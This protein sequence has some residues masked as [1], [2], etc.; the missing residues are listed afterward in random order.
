MFRGNAL[1]QLSEAFSPLR[2][3][4]ARMATACA[5]VVVVATALAPLG[6]RA[7]NHEVTTER[8]WLPAGRPTTGNPVSLH[9][10]GPSRTIYA[11][12]S[13]GGWMRAYDADSLEPKTPA[14]TGLGMPQSAYLVDPSGDLIVAASAGL[15]GAQLHRI[16]IRNGVLVKLGVFDI[17]THIGNE[18]AVVSLYRIPGSN[19]VWGLSTGPNSNGVK[20]FEVDASSPTVSAWKANWVRDISTECAAPMRNNQHVNAALGYLEFASS[21]YFACGSTSTPAGRQLPQLPGVA[22]LVLSGDPLRGPTVAQT[23]ERFSRPGDFTSADS[24][25]DVAS[26]RIVISA[27]SAASGG[28]TFY[29][30]DAKTSSFVGGT[31]G[32]N[33]QFGALGFDSVH[34][35]L[36]GLSQNREFGLLV[37]DVR[38]TPLPQARRYSQYHARNGVVPTILNIGIDPV[39]NRAFLPYNDGPQ[40]TVVHDAGEPVPDPSK[41]DPDVNTSDV[42]E[43]PGRTHTVYSGSAQGFGSRYRW[44]GGPQ[45]VWFNVTGSRTFVGGE[46]SRELRGAYINSLTVG[47]GEAGAAVV[48]AERDG[49]TARDQQVVV[50]PDAPSAGAPWPYQEARCIDFSGDPRSA[51][52]TGA[53]VSCDSA[54]ETA[55]ASATLEE[56]SA[57]FGMTVGRSEIHGRSRRDPVRGTVVTVTSRAEN[58]VVVDAGRELLRMGEVKV[59][60]E[61]WAR[62]R[63]G[64][65]GSSYK[66]EVKDVYVEG[67]QRCRDTCTLAELDRL[68]KTLVGGRLSVRFPEPDPVMAA[69]SPGGYQALVRRSLPEQLQ[70]VVVN[71]QAPDRVEVPGAVVTWLMDNNVRSRVILDL[72]ATAAE[73]RYG[74]TRV[75]GDSAPDPDLGG[76]ALVPLAALSG[77]NSPSLGEGSGF[78]SLSGES[79]LTGGAGDLAP[80]TFAAIPTSVGR[81]AGLIWNGIGGALRLFPIWAVLLAPVYLSARRWLLLQRDALVPGDRS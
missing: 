57:D 3:R 61:A 2:S 51:A 78:G 13:G 53:A 80:T 23:L 75:G 50:T 70:E 24:L 28:A 58:V 76:G 16:G 69:G 48:A 14:T 19:L 79:P 1:T 29:G 40:F 38:P 60:A 25:I 12:Q 77:G 43:A 71:S 52:A 18:Q 66:R 10:H 65:A 81:T 36:Y 67:E 54:K 73:A 15:S 62:G 17:R 49:N 56:S 37:A 74:I 55:T 34:G 41:E 63:P 31:S 47:N 45:N 30:F 9:I 26:G 33:D 22:R 72:A 32:G 42:A 20:V 21:L 8:L 68:G 6:A 44:L 64:T 59:T 27:H 7:H 46:Q 11:Y 39:R 5:I 35:R 4:F